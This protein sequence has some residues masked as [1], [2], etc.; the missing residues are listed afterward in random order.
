MKVLYPFRV[1]MGLPGPQKPIPEAQKAKRCCWKK[2]WAKLQQCPMDGMWGLRGKLI[3]KA[4]GIKYIKEFSLGMLGQI[5][6]DSWVFPFQCCSV[7]HSHV[8]PWQLHWE[9]KTNIWTSEPLLI[10]ETAELGAIPLES[11]CAAW[12]TSPQEE[13]RAL[14]A[15]FQSE[16]LKDWTKSTSFLIQKGQTVKSLHS[17]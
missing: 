4:K 14:A 1:P 10:Q 2:L 6:L 9:N 11:T 15:I 5:P 3:G 16:R 8:H 13:L 12:K 17:S 7:P